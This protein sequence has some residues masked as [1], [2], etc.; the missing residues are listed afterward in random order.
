MPSSADPVTRALI[1]A[2]DEVAAALDGARLVL[3][4]GRSGAGKTTLADLLTRRRPDAALQ[5]LA[6]DAVYPGWDGMAAGVEAVLQ[7]VLEPFAR[8][9]AG[10]WLRWDWSRDQPAEEHVIDADRPL[11]VEGSGILTPQ[12]ARLADVRVWL[13]SPADARKARALARDGESYR[14]HWERWA[15]Q[16]ERHLAA[17]HPEKWATHVIDVP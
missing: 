14:P 7:G 10:R 15:A 2:T 16:E 9:A 1:A 4:D 8:G 12:T 6:L 11:I 3:I 17:D 13:R 5:V